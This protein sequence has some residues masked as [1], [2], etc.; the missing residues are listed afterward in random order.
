MYE[1]KRKGLQQK[2]EEIMAHKK[3]TKKKGKKKAV[4]KKGY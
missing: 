3:K 4:K 1:T 2:N